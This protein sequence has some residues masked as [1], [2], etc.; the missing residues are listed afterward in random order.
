MHSKHPIAI[1]HIPSS[2]SRLSMLPP[3]WGPSNE[4]EKKKRL[5]I[6]SPS[7]AALSHLALTA[8]HEVK[9]RCG[10]HGSFV[11]CQWGAGC[12][13]LSLL[14]ANV[15]PSPTL[16]SV[17]K[18]LS[19]HLE[20]VWYNQFPGRRW[21]KRSQLPLPAHFPFPQISGPSLF[22]DHVTAWCHSRP[23]VQTRQTT[24]MSLWESCCLLWCAHQLSLAS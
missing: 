17:A 15:L 5:T 1:F 19:A 20:F 9:A 4:W 14:E 23:C 18:A 8:T 16:F 3:V 21:S 12:S 10:H 11:I 13:E 24:S 7:R 2:T 6:S 22:S